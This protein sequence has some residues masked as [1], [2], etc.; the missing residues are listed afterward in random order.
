MTWWTGRELPLLLAISTISAPHNHWRLPVLNPACVYCTTGLFTHWFLR[1]S[2]VMQRVGGLQVQLSR[3]WD[4][5]VN[6]REIS[7]LFLSLNIQNSDAL[8]WAQ[9]EGERARYFG[10]TVSSV[11]VTSFERPLAVNGWL[12][13]QLKDNCQIQTDSFSVSKQHWTSKVLCLKNE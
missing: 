5:G 3:K 8:Y 12:A 11:C 1:Q 4:T 9:R 13:L 10:E 6:T 7:L 2:M